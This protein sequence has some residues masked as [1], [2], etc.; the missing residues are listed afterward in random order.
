VLELDFKGSEIAR[1]A[2]N[3]TKFYKNITIDKGREI[4]VALSEQEKQ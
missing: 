3:L 2:N 4:F 1:K